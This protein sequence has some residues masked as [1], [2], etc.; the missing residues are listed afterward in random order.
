M[1][2]FT[3]FVCAFAQNGNGD[4]SVTLING[5]VVNGNVQGISD[6]GLEIKVGKTSRTYPWYALSPGTRF[7]YD[8][9]YRMNLDGY[10]AGSDVSQLTN[11]P[12]PDYDPLNPGAPEASES[13][14]AVSATTSLQY[15]LFGAPSPVIPVQV[16]AL[17]IVPADTLSFYALQYG[18]ASDEVAL[19]G[20]PPTTTEDL[21]ILN[22]KDA[23]VLSEKVTKRKV[24]DVNFKAYPRM[25]F[26]STIDSITAEQKVQWLID[27]RDGLRRYLHAEVTLTRGTQKSSFVLQGDAAGLKPGKEGVPPKPLLVEPTMSFT[28][29][30]EDE[31]AYLIGRVRMARLNLLPRSGMDLKV[32]VDITDGSG[33][34]FL[35]RSLAFNTDGLPDA[36]PLRMEL[37]QLL[38]GQSYKLTATMSLGALLDKVSHEM[39]FIMPD[40]MKL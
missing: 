7:K 6:A 14:V 36:Y 25:S 39:F 24:A 16:P 22:M 5:V 11:A 20:F 33:R 18:S 10:L 8:Q 9:S 37:D 3:G 15:G 30:I 34:S 29:Q 35:K 1:W 19:F 27:D 38:A 26:E 31:K 4:G 17:S 40:A 28:I 21:V 13:E 12:D 2:T 23:R 32:E